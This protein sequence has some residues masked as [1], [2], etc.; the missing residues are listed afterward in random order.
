MDNNQA[1]LIEI[2]NSS[3]P[4][5]KPRRSE[6]Y[7]DLTI[8]CHGRQF[9]VHRTILCPQSE[10]ISKLCDIDMQERKTGII[11]HEEFDDDTVERMIDFTY[12]KNYDATQRPKH[13]LSGDGD[14]TS[15]GTEALAIEDVLTAEGLTLPEND[16]AMPVTDNERPELSAADKWIIHA[17]VYGL[18]DY[19]DMSELRELAH[20]RFMAVADGQAASPDLS[21]FVNVARE[22]CRRTTAAD[23]MIAIPY[24]TSLRTG[25]LSLIARYASKLS[26]DSDF[27]AGLNEPDLRNIMSDIF[28]A[29][30]QRIFE[31]E[32]QKIEIIASLE[33]E[34]E[35]LEKSLSTTK[36]DAVTQVNTAQVLQNVADNQLQRTEGLMQHLVRSLRSLPAT[37]YNN[38]CNNEFGSLRFERGGNE[39]NGDWQVRCGAKRCN[40]KLN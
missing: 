4:T 12:E 40:C 9:K 16:D 35:A 39:G 18:A 6:K 29:L 7:S 19:Y 22:V 37:C 25:F 30:G 24:K 23:G 14:E 33:A 27:V 31:L 2:N 28:C 10:V 26:L 13:L 3:T 11:E 5:S 15:T 1:A 17:R 36:A 20:S 32:A 34:N 38:N 21:G 8:S